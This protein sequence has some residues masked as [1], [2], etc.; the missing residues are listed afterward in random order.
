MQTIQK[1]LQNIK[2]KNGELNVY[3]K[4]TIIRGTCKLC[5]LCTLAK[6]LVIGIFPISTKLRGTNVYSCPYFPCY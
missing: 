6:M 3:F 1:H 2:T 4:S 5:T